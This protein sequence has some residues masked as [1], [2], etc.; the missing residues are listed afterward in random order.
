MIAQAGDPHGIAAGKSQYRPQGAGPG[1]GW[2]KQQGFLVQGAGSWRRWEQSGGAV[3]TTTSPAAD[4][5]TFPCIRSPVFP[6]LLAPTWPPRLPPPHRRCRAPGLPGRG[7][8]MSGKWRRRSGT[9][10]GGPWMLLRHRGNFC[11]R[12]RRCRPMMPSATPGPGASPC[13]T[14]GGVGALSLVWQ[15]QTLFSGLRI[16]DLIRSKYLMFLVNHSW[17]FDQRFFEWS[18]CLIDAS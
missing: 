6:A 10:C 1:L 4:F 11:S 12:V 17:V 13:D 16:M 7:C 5:L 3:T 15:K 18:Q 8:W 2:F 14:G 9:R